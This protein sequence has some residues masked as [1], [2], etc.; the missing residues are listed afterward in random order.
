LQSSP[1]AKASPP[2]LSADIKAE[3]NAQIKQ[4]L[5]E[6]QTQA[7]PSDTDGLPNSL[8]PGHTLFRVST[9]LDVPSDVSGRFCSLGAN[10]Y[11][12]RTGDM[13]ENGTV[14]VQVKLSDISDCRTG[15]ATRVSV[16]DLE[17]MDNE[18]QQALTNALLAASKNMG[19]SGLPQ[20]P[21]TSP[22]L[23]AAGRTRPA[24]DATQTLSRLQ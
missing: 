6:R 8:N 16:N 20:G 2:P 12:E 1:P 7:T 24:P 9:P 22:L 15:L 17:A 11:I 10:D 18:Q 13:D 21:S 5:A 3:L 23:V 19:A 4:Q 14:P